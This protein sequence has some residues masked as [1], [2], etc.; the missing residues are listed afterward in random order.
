ME[1]ESGIVPPSFL[2]VYYN[3]AEKCIIINEHMCRPIVCLEHAPLD[4]TT[5]KSI[6]L[7]FPQYSQPENCTFVGNEKDHQAT[8]YGSFNIRMSGHDVNLWQKMFTNFFV[9]SDTRK[10]LGPIGGDESTI[11]YTAYI[12]NV[13]AFPSTQGIIISQKTSAFGSSFTEL[14][15]WKF[16]PNSSKANCTFLIPNLENKRE[17]SVGIS[18]GRVDGFYDVTIKRYAKINMN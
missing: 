17:N 1:Y 12:M 15:R 9:L 13:T 5:V 10:S 7:T 6:A 14:A 8:P 11:E 3:H 16:A 4:L 18:I 2:D